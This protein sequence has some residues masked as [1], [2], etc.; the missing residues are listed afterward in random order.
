MQ[1]QIWNLQINKQLIKKKYQQLWIKLLI[2]VIWQKGYTQAINTECITFFSFL[3]LL[4]IECIN[5]EAFLCTCLIFHL[6]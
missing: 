4:P 1:C 6:D 3:K 2:Q 5:L